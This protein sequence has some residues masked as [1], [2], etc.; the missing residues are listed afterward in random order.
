ME[1]RHDE[2]RPSDFFPPRIQMQ[3]GESLMGQQCNFKWKTSKITQ[4]NAEIWSPWMFI[5]WVMYEESKGIRKC[6]TNQIK[7][8]SQI[9]KIHRKETSRVAT[10]DL[11]PKC[12]RISEMPVSHVKTKRR[13]RWSLLPPTQEVGSSTALWLLSGNMAL[14]VS[15]VHSDY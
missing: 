12:R 3:C 14:W 9:S 6:S 15:L 8:G 1:D 11:G 7:L 2:R 13:S 10:N 4:T 5:T